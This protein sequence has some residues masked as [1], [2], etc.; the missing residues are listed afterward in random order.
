MQGITFIYFRVWCS[1][2]KSETKYRDNPL[3]K[4]YKFYSVPAL[5]NHSIDKKF[6]TVIA[7]TQNKL[8][9]VD[10]EFSREHVYLIPKTKVDHYVDK[11]V[12]FN[13]P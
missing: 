12:Y 10:D 9:V 4:Y 1:I 5:L 2:T 6:G 13:I 7:E 8:I 3:G 11:Q